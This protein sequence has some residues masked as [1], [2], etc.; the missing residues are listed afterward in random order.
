MTLQSRPE[1]YAT[2]KEGTLVIQRWLPGSAE[3]LWSWLVDADKRRLWLADGVM[4]PA[5][6]TDLEL[7]WRN[8]ELSISGDPVPPGFPEGEQRMAS[9]VVTF[10]APRRLVFTWG[11]GEVAFDLLEKAGQVLLTITHTGLDA[12]RTE[13][14]AGWHTHLDI[15]AAV[16]TE[17]SPPSFWSTWIERNRQYGDRLAPQ[18]AG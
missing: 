7:I 8:S 17:A 10:D 12:A 5:A 4:Q 14:F 2:L 15:L 1:D 6:G 3:R 16:A 18:M 11:K 13:I 9:R